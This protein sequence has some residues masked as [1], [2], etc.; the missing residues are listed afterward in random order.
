MNA[1]SKL[2]VAM[3][4]GFLLMQA[5]Q[6]LAGTYT[7]SY[8]DNAIHFPGYDPNTTSNPSQNGGMDVIGGTP[9]L[10]GLDVVW[11][12]DGILQSITIHNASS[13]FLAFDSLFINND[14]LRGDN[15]AEGWDYLVHNG[16]NVNTSNTIGTVPGNGLWQVSE[17]YAY[18]RVG[19]SSI[20]RTNHANGI[21]ANSL[22]D[23]SN[24]NII[25]GGSA[26]DYT[27]TYDFSNF[28]I[29]LFDENHNGNFVI[30]YTPYCAND[31]LYQVGS[32][33]DGQ[34]TSTKN[35]PEPITLVLFGAGLA[36][37]AGWR[38]RWKNTRK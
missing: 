25:S 21:D 7:A 3:M 1:Y 36:S 28:T 35:V 20:G 8:G 34:Y 31:V 9:L 26:G 18:T 22:T 33:S 37:L 4:A 30:G 27:I 32:W 12:D 16:S 5:G 14:Y 19:T 2:A 23:Q 6:A 13:S 10:T 29:A 11:N 17:V 24:M 38:N 15:N